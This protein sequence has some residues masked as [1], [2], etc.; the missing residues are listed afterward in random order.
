[1]KK[2]RTLLTDNQDESLALADHITSFFNVAFGR[3]LKTSRATQQA[4]SEALEA[5]YTTD[6]I[7]LAFWSARCIAGEQWIK[8]V[9]RKDATPELALRHKGGLNTAT[10]RYARRWLDELS[11]RIGETDPTLVGHFLA[12]LPEEMRESER[13]LLRRNSISWEGEVSE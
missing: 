7:R 3:H 11:S 5:G 9:L 2:Q 1:M 6:E 12:R 13:E 4:I 8:D 10:M